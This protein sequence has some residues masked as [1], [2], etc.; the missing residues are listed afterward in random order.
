M[1]FH[2]LHFYVEDAAFWRDWFI[3]KLA[4]QPASNLCDPT[5][6]V[7]VQGHI[8]IRLSDPSQLPQVGQY[9]K[10]HPPGIADVSFATDCFDRVL[11]RSQQQGAQLLSPVSV[12]S[13][14]QR[15]CQLQGWA[16]LRHTLVE[17]SPQWIADINRPASARLCAVDHVVLNVPQGELSAATSWYRRVFGLLDGQRFNINTARS[18][19][20]SQ[21]LVHPAGTL[22]I[23]IN[24]PSSESSQVQEFLHHNRGAGVQHVAL[25]AKNAL[26]AV[27]HFRQHGLA[28]ISVPPTYYEALHHRPNCPMPDTSAV[29]DQQLLLDW[30]K[31]GKQGMLLQ[32]F[33]EP[34]FAAPTFFFEI[35]ERGIY[36]E[37]SQIKAASGFGE[38]NFQALFEA[39][40]R[41]QIE[42]SSRFD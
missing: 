24:E 1:H 29:A 14:G 18:G 22:Q 19:L 26:E 17:V 31:S 9:L 13:A 41:A 7:L 28:L 8:E 3:R 39:I 23:P 42:R 12:N 4:F 38:G 11:R 40:E 21:V 30:A 5:A 35:I 10:H 2:H 6:A 36:V 25:R 37:N 27:A 33:T 32:T 16:D 34:I 15:Q 20:R